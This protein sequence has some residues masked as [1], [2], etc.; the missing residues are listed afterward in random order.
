MAAKRVKICGCRYDLLV[1]V[2]S[3]SSHVKTALFLRCSSLLSIPALQTGPAPPCWLVGLFRC[4]YHKPEPLALQGCLCLGKSGCALDRC[5]KRSLRLRSSLG[6]PRSMGVI[7][8]RSAGK[9]TWFWPIL[10]L[11]MSP[12]VSLAQ[13]RPLQEGRQQPGRFL[14][15][16][17]FLRT[18]TLKKN[19]PDR[20]VFAS[21][22]LTT[23]KPAWLPLQSCSGSC[24]PFISSFL[25]GHYCSGVGFMK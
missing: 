18:T 6:A 20:A 2:G 9:S 11:Q 22:L 4:R 24:F 1:A 5:P 17:P 12:A 10:W 16:F 15:L 7:H 14:C 19:V 25:Q 21:L 3:A 8:Q 23:A 13:I